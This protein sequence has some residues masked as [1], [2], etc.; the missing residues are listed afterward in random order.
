MAYDLTYEIREA[1]QAGDTALRSLQE[2]RRY[3]NSAGNWGIIDILGGGLFTDLIKHSKVNNAS[4]CMEQAKRD[5]SRFRR[6]LDDVDD[7]LPDINVGEFMTFADFFFDG[8]LADVMM[9]SRISDAKKQVDQ[10]I[11]QVESIVNRLKR[12]V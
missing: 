2:A 8:F 9:Q 12:E 7:Y 6:E 5:L 3:L 4:R 10:A 1:I 11:Y